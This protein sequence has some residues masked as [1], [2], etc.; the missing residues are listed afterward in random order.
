LTWIKGQLSNRERAHKGSITAMA[1]SRDRKEWLT[2][3]ADLSIR[4]WPPLANRRGEFK[5]AHAAPISSLVWG[6]GDIAYSASADRIV[7]SWNMRLG[8][9]IASF[10]G[11][12][13]GVNAVAVSP[14]DR[15]L[16]SGSDDTT[17]KI[18]P[19][20][21]GKLDPDRDP[22]T[23]EKHKK[24]ITCLA[25]T[26][27]GKRLLSGSQDQKLMV[28]N[29]QKGSMDFMIAGHKNWITSILQI[30]DKTVITTSDDLTLCAWDLST[31]KEIARVDF[32]V[33]GDCPR[34][35][36]Q[37]GSDRIL[38]GTSSWLIYEFQLLPDAKSKRDAKSS[39]K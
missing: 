21:E 31:G 24:A 12:S 36:A 14:D 2:A 9:E 16:A 11:H 28:W 35:L 18:W 37:A 1:L 6:G 38:V 27:D 30:D 33:V 26:R 19:I 29:W 32:G 15:W 23:L 17:I 3:G 34:C 25:F 13:E 39:N 7:K 5:K 20:K 8:S 4:S 10:A 22:I